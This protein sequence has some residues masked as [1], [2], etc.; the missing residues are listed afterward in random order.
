MEAVASIMVKRFLKTG[1][2]LFIEPEQVT[3]EY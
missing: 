2:S 1:V 3:A